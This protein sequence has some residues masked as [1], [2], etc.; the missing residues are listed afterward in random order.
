MRWLVVNVVDVHIGGTAGTP[1]LKLDPAAITRLLQTG[2]IARKLHA[3]STAR[4]TSSKTMRPR[5]CCAVCCIEAKGDEKKT[6]SASD[7]STA[8]PSN[9]NGSFT[10]AV[11]AFID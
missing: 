5:I 1:R 2:L 6:S 8:R 11:L 9:K 3:R 10:A 7:C 4:G